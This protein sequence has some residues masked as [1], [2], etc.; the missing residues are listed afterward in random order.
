[1]EC[2]IS[3]IEH[4]ITHYMQ[5]LEAMSEEQIVGCAGGA[6]RKPVD[7]TYEV[8][9][10]N[11]R[12]A[13]RLRGTTPPQEPLETEGSDWWV[14]PSELQSKEAITAYMRQANEDLLSAAKAIPEEE[15]DKL[16][17]APGAER[18]AFAMAQFAALHTMYHDAQL[19][20]IQTLAGDLNVH[21]E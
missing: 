12:I 10:V 19:N 2:A 17:G 21:W 14:A 18:P 13:A 16:V 6:A 7:F 4:A 9:I 8:A 5:D 3:S 1:M 20:F 15:G 11:K